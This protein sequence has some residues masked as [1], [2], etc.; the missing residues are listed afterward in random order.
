ME[1]FTVHELHGRE[2]GGDRKNVA[3][4]NKAEGCGTHL[5][6]HQADDREYKVIEGK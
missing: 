4:L 6:A 5:E 2:L 3:C 1:N